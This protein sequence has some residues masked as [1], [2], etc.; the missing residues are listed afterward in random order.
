MIGGIVMYKDKDLI[1]GSFS[2]FVLIVSIIMSYKTGEVEYGMIIGTS[3]VTL[4]F[5]GNYFSKRKKKSQSNS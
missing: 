1:L 2:L 3:L 4:G 5:W